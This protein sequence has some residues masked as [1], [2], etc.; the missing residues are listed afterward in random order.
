LRGTSRLFTAALTV[1][2]IAGGSHFSALTARAD[3]SGDADTALILAVDVSNSVDATR[4]KL[5]MEGIAQ[6]LEDPGVI[7]AITS[8]PKGGIV[9][10]LVTWA[11]HAQLSLPWHLIRSATDARDF[12]E[13]IRHVP[14]KTGEYTCTSRMFEMVRET[15]LPNIP[16]KAD[17]V[18]LDV[19]GDGIDN[20]GQPGEAAGERDQLVAAGVTINGLPIIVKGE[21]E[22][23][24]SG[25]YRAPGYGLKEL[26]IQDQALTTTLDAWYTANVIGG[27]SGFLLKANGFED[28]GRAFRQKFVSEISS[29][30]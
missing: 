4:Y 26:P 11:D 15:I 5:Q 2:L 22:I 7:Q 24:G 8:G 12:A 17:R 18:V 3:V 23:V 9:L 16:A 13:L 25:A 21:N 30:E 19:S 6:A 1:F 10:S 29:V 27:P 28:F 20:C 14:Q